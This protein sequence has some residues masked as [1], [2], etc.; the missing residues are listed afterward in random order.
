MGVQAAV[1]QTRPMHSSPENSKQ[2]EQNISKA[3]WSPI[4]PTVQCVAPALLCEA[5]C[6]HPLTI[7]PCWLSSCRARPCPGSQHKVSALTELQDGG[8]DN[9]R[10]MSCKGPQKSSEQRQLR[11]CPRGS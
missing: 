6:W 8:E 2:T 7:Q 9:T 10:S 5:A 11:K 1:G 4:R 3:C